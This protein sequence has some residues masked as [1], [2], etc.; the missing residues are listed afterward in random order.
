MAIYNV[1][2]T[3]AIAYTQP[4]AMQCTAI[5]VFCLVFIQCASSGGGTPESVALAGGLK[6][7]MKVLVRL[8]MVPPAFLEGGG[9][10]GGHPSTRYKRAPSDSRE[11][12][13]RF[14]RI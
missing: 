3:H 11:Y 9:G 5:V 14:R 6:A 1:H 4:V 10:G 2:F 13:V 8:V 7:N 12:V